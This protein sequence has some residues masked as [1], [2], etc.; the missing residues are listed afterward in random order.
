M[1]QCFSYRCNPAA[2]D[3]WSDP[4]LLGVTLFWRVKFHRVFTI[5]ENPEY[6]AA[7]KYLAHFFY[8]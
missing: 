4:R 2:P 1:C 5:N 3:L 6:N 8:T 7:L